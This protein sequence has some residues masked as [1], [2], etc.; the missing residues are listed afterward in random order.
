MITRRTALGAGLAF[1]AVA[2]ATGLG[3]YGKSASRHAG[4]IDALLIDENMELPRPMAAWIEASPRAVPIL[5]IS[6]DAAGHARLMHVLDSSG[7]IA[8]IS[9]GATLFCVERIGWDHGFRLTGRREQRASD[10]IGDAC[11]LDVSAF[12]AG[13]SAAAASSSPLVRVYRPS[14]ADGILHAWVMQK[15]DRPQFRQSRGEV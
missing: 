12:L 3:A 1:T 6:L 9:S 10:P 13:S 8:G 15:S 2:G 14:R 4:V 7:A 11:R 5:G